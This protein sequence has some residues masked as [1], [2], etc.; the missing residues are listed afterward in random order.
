MAAGF[1]ALLPLMRR[2]GHGAVREPLD[3]AGFPGGGFPYTSNRVLILGGNGLPAKV[4][5]GREGALISDA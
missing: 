5:E 4:A 3:V 2:A 1:V